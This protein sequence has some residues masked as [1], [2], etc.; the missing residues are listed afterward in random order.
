ME[1]RGNEAQPSTKIDSEPDDGLRYASS[2]LNFGKRSRTPHEIAL[3][4]RCMC[5][6]IGS[7]VADES[8]LFNLRSQSPTVPSI[9]AG[10]TIPLRIHMGGDAGGWDGPTFYVSLFDAVIHYC[11]VG[12]FIGAVLMGFY[13]VLRHHLPGRR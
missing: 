4:S 3:A 12:S 8:W 1:E 7:W 5:W 13:I 6:L 2:S 10:L 9:S 11:L